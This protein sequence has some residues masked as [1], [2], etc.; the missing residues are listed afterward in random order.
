MFAMMLGSRRGLSALCW[1]VLGLLGGCGESQNVRE[2]PSASNDAQAEALFA[3]GDFAAAAQQFLVLSED[4]SNERAHYRLRAGEAWREE[5]DLAA[6]ARAVEGIKVRRLNQDEEL[7]LDLLLAEVALKNHDAARANNL[8]AIN[9]ANLSSALRVRVLELR[10]R[11]QLEGG[12][13]L[14]SARTRAQLDRWLG[15]PDRVQNQNQLIEALRKLPMDGLKQ[16]ANALP[17]GD[18][19]RPWLEQALQKSGQPLPVVVLRPER[20]VGTMIPDQNNTYQREGYRP[21]RSVAL[22]LPS[23]GPIRA[24]AQSV[25]DGFLAAHFANQDEHRP[26][27]LI[28]DSGKTPQDAVAAYQRAVNDGAERV[29]GP[30]TREDVGELFRAGRLPVPVLALNHPDSGETPPAGSAEFGLLPD[31]EAAQV[32]EHMA[33]RGITRVLVIAATDDW[34]ER[35]AL[36]FRAQF[37]QRG[38]Q[39]M[40]EARVRENEVNFSTLIRQ[41]FGALPPIKPPNVAK[42]TIAPPP[43]PPPPD[44]GIFIS[45]RPQQARLLV[46]QLKIAGYNLPIFGTSHIY[47]GTPSPGQDRDLSGVRFCDAPWLYDATAGLPKREDIARDLESARGSG[48]RLFAFGMD[49]YSLLPYMDWLAHHH[50]SYVP[51][52][53]GQLGQ[54]AYGRIHRLLIWAQFDNGVARPVTGELSMSGVP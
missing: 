23:D 46:P 49:A 21:P 36:A 17:P 20:P 43:P 18:P 7:R 41:S 38:G 40:G 42:G 3:Q 31:A 53:T 5:G 47:S 37:E 32:A 48:A 27:V 35:A 29:V 8:L 39:I 51:G 24:V 33:E 15:G 52:A 6:V 2:R 30:L 1:V 28:Y 11:A 4:R 14:G 13:F 16:Q 12:D 44:L 22:L 26:Q 9:D 10:A 45:M 50:D 19:L 25:R 54:D 34:A